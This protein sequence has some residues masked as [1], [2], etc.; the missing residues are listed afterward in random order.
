MPRGGQPLNPD[1][2]HKKMKQLHLFQP[3]VEPEEKTNQKRHFDT[4]L[5]PPSPEIGYDRYINSEMW[6]NKA[7]YA[8]YKK[9]PDCERCGKKN[10][11][12]EVHHKHYNT[13]YHERL[14]DVEVLCDVCH[15]KADQEREK[16]TA[17]HTWADKVYGDRWYS[18]SQYTLDAIQEEFDEWYE[19]IKERE[20]DDW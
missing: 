12:L 3:N 7:R 13:L 17:F 20:E 1:V 6:K 11:V 2:V 10:C 9:G 19:D 18:F 15:P 5:G 4:S 16:E 14:E 8:K